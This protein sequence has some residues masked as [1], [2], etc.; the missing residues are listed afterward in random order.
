[1]DTMYSFKVRAEDRFQLSR[2]TGCLPVNC[3]S[4]LRDSILVEQFIPRAVA[5]RPTRNKWLKR[6]VAVHQPLCDAKTAILGNLYPI[7]DG[8]IG[9]LLSA[10]IEGLGLAA[11]YQHIALARKR[12][13]P[14][15]ARPSAPHWHV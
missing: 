1:M 5:I 3:I 12:E 14:V 8:M 4:S 11:N 7:D 2:V 13:R 9:S 10:L 15:N 6:S